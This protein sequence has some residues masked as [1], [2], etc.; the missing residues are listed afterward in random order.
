VTINFKYIGRTF[1]YVFLLYV[2]LN[3]ILLYVTGGAFIALT[4]SYQWVSS[5]AL[6]VR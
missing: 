6:C 4:W 5:V 2:S 1:S 3:V